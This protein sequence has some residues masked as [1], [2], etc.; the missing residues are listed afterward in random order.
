MTKINIDK[1]QNINV[2]AKR[3]DDFNLSLTIDD[4]NGVPIVFNNLRTIQEEADRLLR[5]YLEGFPN[6]S[7][8]GIIGSGNFDFVLPNGQ[9]VGVFINNIIETYHINT[10]LRDVLL[11]IITDTNYNPV[12]I[13]C[14]ESLKIGSGTTTY[15]SE[16]TIGQKEYARAVAKVVANYAGGLSGDAINNYGT[17]DVLL[18]FFSGFDTV[19]T[20]Q[21][22][23]ETSIFNEDHEGYIAKGNIIVNNNNTVSVVFKN[24]DFKLQQ[25]SYRYS[26]KRLTNLRRSSDFG[27]FP[28]STV[29]R[30]VTTFLTGKIKITE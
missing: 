10:P 23:F 8:D 13:A 30:S 15:T 27:D 16:A 6:L 25:G 11:F 29:F 9:T 5:E 1:A 26:F 14:S 17:E 28:S 18:T 2:I 7:Y 21:D 12:I 19:T 20:T 24:S 3:G 22:D 4:E